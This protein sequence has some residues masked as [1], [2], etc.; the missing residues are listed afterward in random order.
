MNEYLNHLCKIEFTVTLACTGRCRHCQNGD[1]KKDAGHIDAEAAANAVREVCEHY[2]IKTVMTFGG[3]PLLCPDTVCVIHK[4]AAEMKVPRRQVITNGY[5]AADPDRIE[6]T[7]SALSDAG[8]NDLLLSVDA[9][10]QETIPLGP[11]LFFAERAV[12]R[13]IPVRLSP[14][15]LVSAGDNNPY[16]IK[17]REILKKFEHLQIKTGQGNVVFPSGRAL[18]YLSEY[19]D[20]NAAGSSPYE[21]DPE[22]VFTL[23]FSPDG[24]VL[25]GNFYKTDIL[26]IIRSYRP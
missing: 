2:D 3:E 5:F 9:F 10:H 22:D 4:A 24:G 20:R 14:A 13:G 17:T 6:K 8:V 12:H 15:W 1:P 18:T 25:D 16:N 23:S 26:E 19:F 7:V 21:E 11:V